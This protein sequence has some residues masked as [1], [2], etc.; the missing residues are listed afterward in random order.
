MTLKKYF[1]AILGHLIEKLSDSKQVVRDLV[2]ECS[3]CLIQYSKPHQ[4]VLMILKNL[5]HANWH[6][7]EGV[8]ILIARCILIQ[9]TQ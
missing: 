5:Q 4:M 6:V 9:N 7:R 2:L 8:L 3:S 1:T